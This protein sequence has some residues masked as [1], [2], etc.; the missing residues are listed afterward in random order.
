MNYLTK[1]PAINR[2]NIIL[3]DRDISNK[4]VKIAMY[5]ARGLSIYGLLPFPGLNLQFSWTRKLCVP[6]SE[7]LVLLKKDGG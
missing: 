7:L 6:H 4:N 5:H 1:T 2:N 3:I